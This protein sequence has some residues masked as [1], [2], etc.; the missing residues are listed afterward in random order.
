[1]S[2]L[3]MFENR[4]QFRDWLT[5][6]AAISS[7]VWLLF[8]KKGGPQTLS[9]K[10]ALEEALC[11]G[12]I[13]GQMKRIDT[14]TYKKYFTLRRP[15]SKWSKKNKQLVEALSV[16]GRLTALGKE[17][18]AEAKANGQWNQATEPMAISTEDI[19]KVAELLKISELAYQ[20]FVGMPL[21]VQKTYT[22]A[23]L[24]AKTDGGRQNRL[25][26]MLERL[27]KNLKPM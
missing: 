16:Q 24:D 6:N 3:V 2:D 4:E 10:E 17:K 7:G 27:E 20:N 19:S 13:D 25:K 9:A 11:F 1:M 12:W 15:N 14:F 21:S 5:E 26:W 8:G 22:R 23:Y 18:I